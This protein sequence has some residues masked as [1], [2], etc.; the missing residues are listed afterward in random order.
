MRVTPFFNTHSTAH[1]CTILVH[2]T[3]KFWILF[4]NSTPDIHT[5]NLALKYNNKQKKNER[6]WQRIYTRKINK[7]LT[8]FAWSFA[9]KVINWIC[10][11]LNFNFCRYSFIYSTRVLPNVLFK[12]N[13][14]KK[15][16]YW[17][18]VNEY[19]HPTIYVV[20]NFCRNSR[21]LKPRKKEP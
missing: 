15:K 17:K 10:R 12:E 20:D 19:T 14:H 9:S 21:K 5:E 3:C 4:P 13:L 2:L 8:Q 7:F 18:K 16:N 1:M 6:M 11:F